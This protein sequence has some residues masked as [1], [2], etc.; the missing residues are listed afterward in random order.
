M[1]ADVP[2]EEL[3]VQMGKIRHAVRKAAEET[4]RLYREVARG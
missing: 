3:F 2:L 1:A 4:L